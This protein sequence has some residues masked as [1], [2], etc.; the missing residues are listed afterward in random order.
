MTGV[1][2]EV[3]G[4]EQRAA[5]KE[6]EHCGSEPAENQPG[7]DAGGFVKNFHVHG[8]A[9]RPGNTTWWFRRR[10]RTT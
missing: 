5:E 8:A 3:E 4:G 6:I 1:T 2:V 7:S 9:S 10:S